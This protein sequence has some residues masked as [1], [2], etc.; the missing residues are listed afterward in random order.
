[1][2]TFSK[3]APA[4]TLI[5]CTT[6]DTWSLVTANAEFGSREEHAAVV[7]EYTENEIVIMGGRRT[8][9]GDLNDV[10]SSSDRGSK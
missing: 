4:R 2:E 7:L 10:W 8:G 1:M 5:L 3:Q 9:G 6:Q